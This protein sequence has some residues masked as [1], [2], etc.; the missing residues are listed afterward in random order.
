MITVLSS[1]VFI[2]IDI[3]GTYIMACYLRVFNRRLI[4]NSKI[5]IASYILW[6]VSSCLITILIAK[7]LVLIIFNVV[8]AFLLTFNYSSLIKQKVISVAVTMIIS[9]ITEFISVLLIGSSFNETADGYVSLC[10]KILQIGIWIILS[11]F[12]DTDIKS[13]RSYLQWYLPIIFSIMML[14]LYVLLQFTDL[15]VYYIFLS[16]FLMITL[17]ASL[18]FIYKLDQERLKSKEILSVQKAESYKRQYRQL[19]DSYD[20]FNTM[21]HNL[22]KNFL[23]L[24]K[25]IKE[26]RS[27]ELIEEK[28]NEILLETIGKEQLIETNNIEIDSIINA[29]IK[30][31][32]EKG[33]EVNHK[34]LIP[35]QLDI[36]TEIF[37]LIV[38]NIFDVAMEETCRTGFKKLNFIV[39]YDAEYL[40]SYWIHPYEKAGLHGGS[41]LGRR[42]FLKRNKNLMKDIEA[43]I[44]I[45]NGWIQC[46]IDEEKVIWD[47]SIYAGKI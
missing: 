4:K 15:D 16:F 7:P 24:N 44:K 43:A 17:V 40:Y 30:E 35:E 5:E 12:W 21:R 34:I 29:K 9:A 37:F 22:T 42:M 25:M 1:A 11:N 38:N 47:V 14:S 10:S 13:R 20:D 3:I 19:H 26:G 27:K 31:S 8:M 41:P 33:L 45:H 36:D 23:V 32:E 6:H 2:F 18:I 28:M 39:R 46:I